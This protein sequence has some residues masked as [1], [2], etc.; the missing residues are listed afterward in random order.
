M[1]LLMYRLGVFSLGILLPLS[2]AGCGGQTATVKGKVLL[3]G[4]PLHRGQLTFISDSGVVRPALIGQ[5]GN[6]SVELPPGGMK[7]TVSVPPYRPL[8]GGRVREMDPAKFGTKG[9]VLKA[10]DRD[11]ETPAIP[12]KYTLREQTPLT[13]TATAGVQEHDIKIQT[14]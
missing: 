5:D 2:S 9:A 4:K 12:S 8:A 11:A 14:K 3:D 10:S 13:Y 6:Y 1:R 7:I